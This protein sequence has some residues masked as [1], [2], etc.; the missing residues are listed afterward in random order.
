KIP[1]N[2]LR[3][4][5]EL[6]FLGAKWEASGTAEPGP[7]LKNLA[8]GKI[9]LP[10]L[11]VM[12]HGDA[13]RGFFCMAAADFHTAA[14]ALGRSGSG[15]TG[16]DA[17]AV[18]TI[19]VYPHKS[20][21]LLKGAVLKALA[22]AGIFIHATGS[23]ISAITVIVDYARLDEAI[24][25]LLEVL[26]LAEGHAPFYQELD[27]ERFRFQPPKTAPL[28]TEDDNSFLRG[29]KIPVYAI[30]QKTGL[31]LISLSFAHTELIFWSDLLEEA[32]RQGA[33]FV[34]AMGQAQPNGRQSLLLLAEQAGAQKIASKFAAQLEKRPGSAMEVT[35]QAESICLFGPHFEDRYGIADAA[36]SM[37]SQKPGM[38][39]G[40]CC[41]GTS[42]ML[43]TPENMAQE[44]AKMLEANFMVPRAP[45]RKKTDDRA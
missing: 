35:N 32:G 37:L 25:C 7:F 10:F 17:K 2:G 42:I 30:N 12:P 26:D 1:I 11:N 22:Q 43:V 19:M 20:S 14:L 21:L 3:I 23:S 45:S 15:K 8:A 41:T 9:N 13:L 6:A 44:A 5:S 34:L 29:S 36:I 38:L 31:G 27:M 33:S 18:G 39:V 4:S 28:I 16:P 24:S 40:A